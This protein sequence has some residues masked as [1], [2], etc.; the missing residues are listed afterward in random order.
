[1]FTGSTARK[2]NDHVT[3]NDVD[4]VRINIS[5]TIFQIQPS[6]LLRFPNS[7][8]AKL[9]SSE[10]TTDKKTFYFDQDATLFGHILR[11]CRS[12]EVH[13][14]SLICP[15]EFMRELQYWDIP[16]EKIAPCC[17]PTFYRADDVLETLEKVTEVTSQSEVPRLDTDLSLQERIWRFMDDPYYSKASKVCT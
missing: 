9:A 3:D 6:T 13:V 5:G 14:P 16:V 2:R 12:G 1:M 15:R 10:K 4:T 11:C 7:R 8:L 17:W